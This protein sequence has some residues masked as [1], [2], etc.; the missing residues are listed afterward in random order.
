[1]KSLSE[2][3]R[4]LAKCGYLPQLTGPRAQ[5]AETW[6]GLGY[7]GASPT[8]CPGYSTSLPETIEIARGRLHWSKG[9]LTEFC[10]GKPSDAMLMGIE[11]C[12]GAS[13]EC[14]SWCMSNREKGG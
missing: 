10:G 8:I 7:S 4:Q 12:E 11:I 13:N 9:A 5:F 14:Q 2:E 1:M 3:N 6:C